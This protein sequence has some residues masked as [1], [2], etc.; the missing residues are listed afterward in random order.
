M[1]VID[2]QA[3]CLRERK[4]ALEAVKAENSHISTESQRRTAWAAL[5]STKR[6]EKADGPP[7]DT[8]PEVA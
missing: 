8:S 2:I 1:S 3:A 6:A 7:C 4:W 5:L